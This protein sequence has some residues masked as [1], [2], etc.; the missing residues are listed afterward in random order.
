MKT[1]RFCLSDDI[2]D[3]ASHCRH[4][5]KRLHWGKPFAISLAVAL[6][7]VLCFFLVSEARSTV[8][9][10]SQ[11][12]NLK[13]KLD[14]MKGVCNAGLS[15]DFVD[16]QTTDFQNSIDVSSL[17]W[18]D[19]QSLEVAWDNM[20]EIG[21]CGPHARLQAET[22][23]RLKAEA[24]RKRFLASF[25]ICPPPG[26]SF[27]VIT[28]PPGAEISLDGDPAGK[29][30]KRLCVS[31]GVHDISL[32]VDGMQIWADSLDVVPGQERPVYFDFSDRTT[33]KGEPE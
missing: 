14:S 33:W 1:C 18:D 25:Q 2:P 21:G 20:L 27:M 7:I 22:A 4:C 26:T 11:R 9:L 10:E 13:I 5:G 3:Q 24:S 6:G 8:V 31:E 32:S 15:E 28:T 23:K 19:R 12:S 16:A 17:P 30:P 29:S